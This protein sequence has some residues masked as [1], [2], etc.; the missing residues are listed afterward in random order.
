M[1]RPVPA[2]YFLAG[3]PFSEMAVIL[4][5]G[6]LAAGTALMGRRLR[7]EA[8]EIGGG[9]WAFLAAVLAGHGLLA[10]SLTAPG[11]WH[12]NHGVSV[13]LSAEAG[14][15]GLTAMHGPA[16]ASVLGG[17]RAVLPGSPSVFALNYLLSTVSAALGFVSARLVLGDGRAALAAACLLLFLPGR[18]RLSASE[19]MANLVEFLSLSSMTFFLLAAKEPRRGAFFALGCGALVILANCRAEMLLLA[20]ILGACVL[21]FLAPRA[22]PSAAWTAA[23]VLGAAALCLPR[24]LELISLGDSR[25]G[26]FDFWNAWGRWGPSGLNTFLDGGYT[27]ALHQILALAGLGALS[28]GRPRLCV[29]L[30]FLWLAPSVFYAAHLNCDATRVRTSLVGHF[31]LA[32]MAAYGFSRLAERFAQDRFGP[33]APNLALAAA[34]IPSAAHFSEFLGRNHLLQQD[35][36]FLSQAAA[37]LPVGAAVVTLA[38]E[39]DPGLKQSRFYQNELV[40][41]AVGGPWGKARFLG[42]RDFLDAKRGKGSGRAFFYLG[43]SCYRKPCTGAGV[44]CLK[45]PAGFVHPLCREMTEGFSLRAL[46]VS[47]VDGNTNGWDGVAPGG[48]P[49]GLYQ[50]MG[51]RLTPE[52]GSNPAAS[53]VPGFWTRQAFRANRAGAPRLARLALWSALRLS[54]TRWERGAAAVLYQELGDPEAALSAL[55]PLSGRGDR[56]L[57]LFRAELQSQLGRRGGALNELEQAAAFGPVQRRLIAAVYR[58]L[59][60]PARALAALGVDGDSGPEGRIERA[61][62]LFAAG[63]RNSALRELKRGEAPDW[64]GFHLVRAANL[65]N[66]IRGDRAPTALDAS[67]RRFSR[68]APFHLARAERLMELGAVEE[69]A[70]WL[71]RADEASLVQGVPADTEPASGA[72]EG[73]AAAAALEVLLQ[74][75]PADPDLHLRRAEDRARSGLRPEAAESLGQALSLG[76]PPDGL[77]RAARLY[78]SMQDYDSAL[79]IWKGLVLREDRVT[80]D[81]SDKGVCEYLKGDRKQ[82]VADLQKAIALA[83]GNLEAYLS[84]G[85]IHAA[86]GDWVR[87]LEIYDRGLSAAPVGSDREA[88]RQLSSARDGLARRFRP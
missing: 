78:Q 64:N 54:P 15:P 77:R 18:M 30:N 60:Q 28:W 3:S 43:G 4:C 10:A 62:L 65:L 1:I 56:F 84:L 75:R 7:R 31:P 19:D 67:W 32:L 50:I 49:I 17:L 33:W 34:L 57:G 35:H 58:R 24:V 83:P 26:R 88:R 81:F 48:G 69:A 39:D 44:E 82:G 59:G 61:E 55:A 70:R 2:G 38:Q 76:L 41:A 27:P 21:L 29:G 25:A 9:E 5:L 80:K 36:R 23:A 45:A 71:R 46:G 22:A 72:S 16:Y 68:D 52:A 63:K 11:I 73:E 86:E 53:L 40:D 79:R 6:G 51:V 85:S 20:P 42:I 13:A 47:S 87:A 12:E 37:W 74:V 66:Q 14:F 8:A